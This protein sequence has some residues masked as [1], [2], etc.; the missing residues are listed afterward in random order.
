MD[1]VMESFCVKDLECI[2]GPWIRNKTMMAQN[3]TI[4]IF[5]TQIVSNDAIPTF[6]NRSNPNK[7]IKSYKRSKPSKIMYSHISEESNDSSDDSVQEIR[8]LKSLPRTKPKCSADIIVREYIIKNHDLYKFIGNNGVD[9]SGI[10]KIVYTLPSSTTLDIIKTPISTNHKN[11]CQ[12]EK[13]NR[14]KILP[15][16]RFSKTIIISDSEDEEVSAFSFNT[17]NIVNSTVKVSQN[18][19][20][21]NP[22]NIVNSTTNSSNISIS[23]GFNDSTLKNKVLCSAKD[24]MGLSGIEILCS[25]SGT[26]STY[27]QLG[28]RNAT[29]L[30]FETPCSSTYSSR[31]ELNKPR[32]SLSSASLN[33]N[34]E[35]LELK[36]KPIK[37]SSSTSLNG[38]L[39][40][41]DF[42]LKRVESPT[43]WNSEKLE[44]RRKPKKSASTT[45]LNIESKKHSTKSTTSS[46]NKPRKSVSSSTINLDSSSE[47][48]KP[49]RKGRKS[50]SATNCYSDSLNST[51]KSEDSSKK[52]IEKR[53]SHSKT[54]DHSQRKSCSSPAV[55]RT[56]SEV[57]ASSINNSKMS[58][59][60]NKSAKSLNTIDLNSNTT[61][62]SPN[63][64]TVMNNIVNTV[65][66]QLN[67]SGAEL[68]DYLGKKE[69]VKI[70][71]STKEAIIIYDPKD[72][73][74]FS[75]C[76]KNGEV[77]LS[78]EM[79]EKF[80]GKFYFKKLMKTYHEEEPY[81]VTFEMINNLFTFYQ[82]L[83]MMMKIRVKTKIH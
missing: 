3:D 32:R 59:T 44:S 35:K 20:T 2:V 62:M 61:Q 74:M 41:N 10:P 83:H 81:K 60:S 31:D 39:N 27:Q 14:K 33:F 53:V 68:P 22:E 4:S 79:I 78:A 56:L 8:Y 58:Q 75:N 37:T 71:S 65:K 34:S 21:F 49:L 13:Q 76:I 19:I 70:R 42:E 38:D 52:K 45:S 30:I 29:P 23:S 50:I 48:L 12:S 54:L 43:S 73:E 7:I 66:K 15:E 16:K 77:V 28:D 47:V 24:K 63:S 82:L 17:G 51:T 1:K 69:N 18:E 64:R 36:N 55:G 57:Y 6:K 5:K 80:I 25:P 67:E 9:E 40:F 26:Q 46:S 11:K 72:K